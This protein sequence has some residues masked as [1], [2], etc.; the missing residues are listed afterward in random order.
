MSLDEQNYLGDWLL[1]EEDPNYCREEITIDASQD[2]VSGTLLGKLAAGEYVAYD[3]TAQTG[4]QTAVGIL[5]T[6]QVTTGAGDSAKAVMLARGPAV[7]KE[8]GLT[9]ADPAGLVD[10]AALSPKII[11]RENA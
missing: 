9:G 6:K 7:V 1:S 5:V 11:V 3:N 8:D 10:L 4:E 2:L